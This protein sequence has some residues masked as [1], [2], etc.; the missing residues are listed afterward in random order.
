M[1]QA[2]PNK[3]CIL[4][5]S[6]GEYGIIFRDPV[7]FKKILRSLIKSEFDL[8]QLDDRGRAH[9]IKKIPAPFL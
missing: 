3:F 1:N 5:L 7:Q 8:F 2:A 9:K 4:D 6:D